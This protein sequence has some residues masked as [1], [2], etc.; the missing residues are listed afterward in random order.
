MKTFKKGMMIKAKTTVK[1]VSPSAKGLTAGKP[2]KQMAGKPPRSYKELLERVRETLAKG[3]ARAQ[4]ALE[5]IQTRMFWE[6]GRWI[7]LYLKHEKKTSGRAPYGE[8]AIPKLSEDLSY[9]KDYL[10]D[11]LNVYRNNTIFG[12]YRKLS[13]VVCCAFLS[14]CTHLPEINEIVLR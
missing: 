3:R 10:Y 8:K 1:K 9:D 5:E 12:T 11:S 13:I 6:T 7:H 4:K 2:S 14:A